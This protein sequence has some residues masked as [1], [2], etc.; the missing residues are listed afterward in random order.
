MET[1]DDDNSA[2]E[3]QTNA[4]EISVTELANALKRTIEDRFGLVR[5]RGEISNYRGPHSSGHAYFCLKDQSARLDAVIWKGDFLRL[6]TGP[7]K[8]LE[9]VATGKIT[10]FPG[11]SAYQIVIE[12]IEP[13][14]VGALMALLDE[15][16]KRLA[17]EGLFDEA[18][19][20]PLPFLPQ[21]D[22]R[23]HLADRRRDP[24][25]SP[26]PRRSLS[27]PRARLAGARAGRDCGGRSRRGDRGLQRAA[28]G[29]PD[30]AARRPHRR[31]RR[32]LARGSLEFQ[33]GNRGARRGRRAPSRLSPPSATRPTRRCSTSSPICARRRRPAPRKRRSRCARSCA[34]ISPRAN[35]GWRRPR[36]ARSSSDAT[37]IATLGRL[38]ATPEQLLQSPR[39]RL[40][41]AAR[42]CAAPCSA[43]GESAAPAPVAA[44][45]SSRPS[46]AA[47]RAG[48][49][50][51]K[52]ARTEGA[53]QTGA[54]RQTCPCSPA[55]RERGPS[56]ER[57][58]RPADPC[59]GDPA[60]AQEGKARA[61][62]AAED[63]LSH[64][65]VL[66]RG[67][68]LVR[69][70]REALLRSAARIES[71]ARLSIEFFDGRI[72][73]RAGETAPPEDPQAARPGRRARRGPG[74]QGSLF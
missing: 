55:K 7:R 52:A 11:K 19:K 39:Q 12:A 4:P 22:R 68:A 29:R 54:H 65:A 32:R 73:A 43:R 34:K 59:D 67:F 71:G 37:Q 63:S 50:E 60:R 58:W 51:G 57:S 18:R 69:D 74:D 6:R 3:R 5:V 61:A 15:R 31:A 24:R 40:D 10:T 42:S 13:A 2:R 45:P 56:A 72:A 53:S 26:P 38:L 1:Q 41:R 46:L 35:G 33:R 16:R 23:R 47:S 21:V 49:R 30:S 48:A 64:K 8:G 36:P 28:R 70:E 14:G 9:V 17:A 66:A 62:G 44:R 20:H 27:A 25:H